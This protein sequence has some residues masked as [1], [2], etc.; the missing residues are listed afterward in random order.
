MVKIQ[1]I[2][3][4]LCR[5][6]PV[7]TQMDFDNSGFLIGHIDDTVSRVL[8]SLDITDEVIEEAASMKANLII[9]H[10]PLIF[11]P[12]K[13]I[14]DRGEGKKLLR[15]AELGIAA[16]C[17]HTNLDIARGGVNDVLIHALGASSDEAL[18]EEG[19]GRIGLLPESLPFPV[20]L[21]QCK[22]RL[23]VNGLRY[24]D[25]GREVHKLAVM[26]G[27]GGDAVEMAY[28]K[29]CDTYVTA[30]IKYHQ[31]LLAR[32]LGINLIDGDH[33]CTE[34]LVIPVLA[35]MLAAEFNDVPFQVSKVHRQ[36]IAFT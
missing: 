20:F 14:T 3:D 30:D 13:R 18:D 36:V 24:Y 25:A 10:H 2:Y 1:E 27:S 6:A 5:F 12:V 33:F 22:D 15:L 9:S 26:G 7:E 32:E 35:E 34:N 4:Y 29:G 31:F 16:I 8:L 21:R 19:C 23:K 17:M 11:K 28:I